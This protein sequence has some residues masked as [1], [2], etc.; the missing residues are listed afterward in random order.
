MI[1]LFAAEG[2][3]GVWLPSDVKEFWWS[4][5]AFGIVFALLLWKLLPVITSG[6]AARSDR[7]RAEM[8]EAERARLDAEAELSELRSKLGSAEA[9][10]ERITSAARDTAEQVKADLI[11]RADADAAEAK[12]KA[13]N[14]LAVSS[15]QAAADIQAVVA[16]QATEAT[17]SVVLANLDDQ[18]HSDLIDRDIEQVSGS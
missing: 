12:T 10:Q 16:N 9:E 2:P 15:G 14:E 18:T 11:A 5:A 4:A 6:L 8:V 7:I 3:N 13:N 17:E 1:S